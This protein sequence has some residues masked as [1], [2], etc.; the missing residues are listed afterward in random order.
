MNRAR[1]KRHR[2]LNPA[3]D[4][5]PVRLPLASVSQ[6]VIWRRPMVLHRARPAQNTR[7]DVPFK[8]RAP[9][10]IILRASSWQDTLNS[11]CDIH[12]Q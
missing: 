9:N 2:I 3:P 5:A 7:H 6:F 1:S 11:N 8:M 4:A 12:E 10:V